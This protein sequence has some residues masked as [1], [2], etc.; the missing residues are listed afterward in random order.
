MVFL[1]FIIYLF[2]GFIWIWI[3]HNKIAI[4]NM[5]QPLVLIFFWPIHVITYLIK[6]LI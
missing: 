3:I 6:F 2:L 1:Y 4:N 5:L